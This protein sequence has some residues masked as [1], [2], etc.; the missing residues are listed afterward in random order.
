MGV[1]PNID[2]SREHLDHRGT[3]QVPL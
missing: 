3:V 2:N 1:A